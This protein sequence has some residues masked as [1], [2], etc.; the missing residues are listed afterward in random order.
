MTGLFGIHQT[1]PE[2]P[3]DPPIF[4][5]FSTISACRP[6]VL[7]KQRGAHRGTAAADDQ[8]VTGLIPCGHAAPPRDVYF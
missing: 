4:G 6:S 1:P 8:Q 3:V 5:C 2:K 7:Y